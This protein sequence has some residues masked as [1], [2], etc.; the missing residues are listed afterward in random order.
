MPE[1]NFIPI[2]RL[3]F[4]WL[5]KL[6]YYSDRR[7]QTNLCEN[8]KFWKLL[9]HTKKEIG[10]FKCYTKLTLLRR[11]KQFKRHSVFS[12]NCNPMDTWLR[13]ERRGMLTEFLQRNL[14]ENLHSENKTR[15]GNSINPLTPNDLYM[16]RTAPLTSKSCILYIYLTNVCTEY[17]KHALY[18]PFFFLFEM[19]FV[20]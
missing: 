9:R 18:S 7:F 6:V 19:Q 10:A 16:S 20:S 15:D 11:E 12:D 5:W 4:I 8:K 17:F 1:V 3:L 2:F 13:Q 14:P